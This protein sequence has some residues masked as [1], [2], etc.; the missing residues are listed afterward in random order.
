MGSPLGHIL[1]DIF[2]SMIEHQISTEINDAVVHRR[3]V[4]DTLVISHDEAQFRKLLDE[5]NSIHP[6]LRLIREDESNN[7]LKFLDITITRRED[8]SIAEVS[9]ERQ[10]GLES[11]CIFKVI[12]RSNINALW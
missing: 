11:A 7:S 2:A 6:N 10:H 4:D 9:I 5:I 12:R 1:T 3:Y 8:G